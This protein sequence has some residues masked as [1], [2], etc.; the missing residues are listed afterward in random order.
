MA[1]MDGNAE[2]CWISLILRVTIVS[3]LLPAGVAKF[4][5]GLDGVV[6]SFQATFKETWLPMFLVTLHA[7]AV[8]FVE[9]VLPVWLLVGIRLRLAWV[10]TSFFMVSLA[11]GML[12]AKQYG[13]AANNYLYV[14]ICCAGLYFSQF[15]RLSLDGVTKQQT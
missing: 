6:E 7:R 3:L 12:V 8:P 2:G 9:I 11:F 14:L 1:K 15:D 5:G 10:V 4:M 13:I